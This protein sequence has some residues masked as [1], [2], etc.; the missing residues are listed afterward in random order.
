MNITLT[1]NS[2]VRSVGAPETTSLLVCFTC[3]AS[4]TTP[5]NGT[6]HSAH[7]RTSFLKARGAY[8]SFVLTR[9]RRSPPSASTERVSGDSTVRLY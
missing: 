3:R 2:E 8:R 4:S 7:A 6:A 1:V 5:T 9:H